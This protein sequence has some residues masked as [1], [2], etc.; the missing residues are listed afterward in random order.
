M[1]LDLLI[2]GKFCPKAPSE[3]VCS[4]RERHRELPALGSTRIA[5]N[6]LSTCSCL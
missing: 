6:L 2:P 3:K 5:F 1:V 4:A